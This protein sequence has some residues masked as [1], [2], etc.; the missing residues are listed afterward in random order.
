MKGSTVS[1]SAMPF[2]MEYDLAAIAKLASMGMYWLNWSCTASTYRTN[3]Y[4]TAP[5]PYLTLYMSGTNSRGITTGQYDLVGN[6]KLTTGDNST[7]TVTIANRSTTANTWS[8]DKTSSGKGYFKTWY[9]QL[10][11]FNT[12][13]AV[14]WCRVLL[15][16]GTSDP[17]YAGNVN[18]K[19]FNCWFSKS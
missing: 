11:S 19:A 7:S 5:I 1:P 14:L 2:R 17:Y 15:T 12:T 10:V 18:F 16:Y 3:G 13:K 6:K 4:N 9:D 8:S